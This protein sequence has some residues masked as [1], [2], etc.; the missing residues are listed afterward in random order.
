MSNNSSNSS[1]NSN[2]NNSSNNN[3]S[4]TV[5]PGMLGSHE[6]SEA[7]ADAPILQ[8]PAARLCEARATEVSAEMA[9][10]CSSLGM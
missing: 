7:A 10:V 6:T 5:M 4:H 3:I 2:N 1:N 9:F 8:R